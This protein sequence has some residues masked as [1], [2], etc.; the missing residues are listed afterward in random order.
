[1]AESEAA[2]RG[3]KEFDTEFR[4]LHPD[5]TVKVLKANAIVIRDAGGKA[6]RMLGLNRD[7][8]ELREAEEKLHRAYSDLEIKVQERTAELTAAKHQLEELNLSLERRVNKEI[9]SRQ[10]KEQLLFQQS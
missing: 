5:E 3:E 4:V 1:M 6:V 2:L 8:T 7:I 10:E 9:A